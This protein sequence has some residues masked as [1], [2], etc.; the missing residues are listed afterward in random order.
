[1]K[2]LLQDF[3]IWVFDTRLGH[4]LFLMFFI[5][6][7][8]SIIL[9]IFLFDDFIKN[10]IIILISGILYSSYTAFISKKKNNKLW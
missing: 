2:K 10:F 1:M 4:F 6:L 5:S 9:L 8:S 7:I 3:M